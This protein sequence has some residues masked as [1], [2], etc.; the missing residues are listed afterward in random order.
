[1]HEEHS[2][3]TGPQI[4]LKLLS[5]RQINLVQSELSVQ[6]TTRNTILKDNHYKTLYGPVRCECSSC[7]V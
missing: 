2:L 1:M 6:S 3:L 5:M 4:V 7:R